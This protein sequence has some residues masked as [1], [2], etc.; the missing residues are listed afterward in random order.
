[1][2]LL[3]IK[4]VQ[5]SHS[6]CTTT[7]SVVFIL[8]LPTAT[9]TKVLKQV[10]S[11]DLL[12]VILSPEVMEGCYPHL[13]P[14][15]SDILLKSPWNWPFFP[16][17]SLFQ[18][19]NFKRGWT[20]SFSSQPDINATVKIPKF[21]WEKLAFILFSELTHRKC[22]SSWKRGPGSQ[23]RSF[24]GC[25]LLGWTVGTDTP[26]GGLRGRWDDGHGRPID[27]LKTCSD[28]PRGRDSFIATRTTS[29]P[30]L[31]H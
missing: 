27:Y 28:F 6:I 30:T 11:G 13:H 1:M 20:S 14:C 12:E 10:R 22:H 5:S 21:L 4:H 29:T 2:Y 24:S 8:I 3:F 26:P 17:I 23:H 16:S 19:A 15:W 31:S 18:T 25:W 7:P 9:N